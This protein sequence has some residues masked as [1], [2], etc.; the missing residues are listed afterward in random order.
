[1]ARWV[2]ACVRNSPEFAVDVDLGRNGLE[3]CRTASRFVRGRETSA[4][5]IWVT[6]FGNHSFHGEHR[7]HGVASIMNEVQ[8]G[9]VVLRV[10]RPG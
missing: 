5:L 9:P 1:M 4:S 8:N 6:S 7:I 2:W 3:L 10:W